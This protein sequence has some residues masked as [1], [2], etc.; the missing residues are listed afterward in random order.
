MPRSRPKRDALRELAQAR[1]SVVVGRRAEA[2]TGLRP[3]ALAVQ[4]DEGYRFTW[5]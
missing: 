2:L 1:G 3:V 5:S 4:T